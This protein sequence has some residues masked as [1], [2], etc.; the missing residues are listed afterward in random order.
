[1]VKVKEKFILTI[2]SDFE[3]I[4]DELFEDLKENT[5]EFAERARQHIND[6]LKD[7]FGGIDITTFKAEYI[8]D[9]TEVIQEEEEEI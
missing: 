2:E 1:M 4:T 3:E 5:N 7:S 8:V 9:D 6:I